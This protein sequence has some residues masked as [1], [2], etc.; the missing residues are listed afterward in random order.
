MKVV[1]VKLSILL[2]VFA[3]FFSSCKKKTEEAY[4]DGIVPSS[5]KHIVDVFELKYGEVKEFTYEDKTI[6]FNIE[7]VEDNRSNPC[8]MLV[9][10]NPREYT[11]KIRIHAY[12]RVEIE[13]N[14]SQLKVSSIPCAPREL[15]VQGVWD[16]LKRL[17]SIPVNWENPTYFEHRFEYSFGEGTLINNT[18]LSIYLAIASHFPARW[19]TNHNIEKSMYEFVFIITN[20]KRKIK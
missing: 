12:L 14:V 10:G 7:D 15:D 4:K 17:E 5:V 2:L 3:G 16:E 20:Q 8:Y 19:E 1:T 18:S 6:K 9:I 13:G 11:E